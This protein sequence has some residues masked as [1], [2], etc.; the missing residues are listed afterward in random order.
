[1]ALKYRRLLFA[2]FILLF[3]LLVPLVLLYATGHTINWQRLSLEKT[4]TLLID[5]EPSEASIFING[6][7]ATSSL[8]D[9]FTPQPLT[10]QARI[11]DLA[12][13]DYVVR[14]ERYGSLSWEERIR[15]APGEALNLGTIRLFAQ[16]KPELIQEGGARQQIASPN[17]AYV[18]LL[19]A[20]S[21]EIVDT[22]NG[23]IDSIPLPESISKENLTWAP[24]ESALLLG[25]HLITL[26]NK[27]I[28]P[29]TDA[30]QKALNGIHWNKLDPSLIYGFNA[31]TVFV[32]TVSSSQKSNYSIK[33]ITANEAIVD[34]QVYREQTYLI[35]RKNDGSEK[36]L[37]GSLGRSFETIDLPNGQYR[38]IL[39]ESSQP[40]IYN[41]RSMFV[42]DK[43]LPLFPKPRLVEVSGRFSVGRWSGQSI[44]YA[45]PLELRRWDGEG[46]DTLLSRFGSPLTALW[47][48][49]DGKTIIISLA[50]G[51][52]AF[53]Q[54]RAAF[55]VNL[56]DIKNT[57]ALAVSQNQK[58]IFAYGE[59]EGIVGLFRFDF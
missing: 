44:F 24:D 59:F 18:A 35:V 49:Q 50:D 55:T 31:N 1:M 5:S 57:S 54:N 23:N 40:L 37:V 46:N 51:I 38:F 13:G 26:H 43:P 36:L 6:K 9:I 45:T 3:C 2:F 39:E 4:A 25:S 47:P 19:Y 34:F 22:G 10:T 21:L 53:S 30:N 52:R 12:P 17:G 56:A 15:L 7:P 58:T 33:E 28:R 14:L 11:K 41:G 27:T 8:L 16:S 32:Q 48:L 29:L 20:Q 42:V